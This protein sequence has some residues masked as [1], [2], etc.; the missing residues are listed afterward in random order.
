MLY[1]ARQDERRQTAVER[2]RR[3]AP[4]TRCASLCVCQT[5]ARGLG[6]KLQAVGFKD[7][8][9]GRGTEKSADYLLY[10]CSFTIE[11]NAA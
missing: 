2:L 9:E 8:K 3:G 10:G 7:K 4:Q 1:G 5:M 6:F 11:W